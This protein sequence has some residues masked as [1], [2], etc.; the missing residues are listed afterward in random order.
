MPPGRGCGARPSPIATAA[1]VAYRAPGTQALEPPGRVW[2]CCRAPPAHSVRPAHTAVGETAY[3]APVH[4]HPSPSHEAPAHSTGRAFPGTVRD[5]CDTTRPRARGM[6]GVV[7]R[8][9][10]TP[11][12]RTTGNRA[13]H[14]RGETHTP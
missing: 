9:V 11:W 1:S 3:G 14:G 13:R 2:W 4:R 6:P 10:P 12:A 8:P 5:A 7:A